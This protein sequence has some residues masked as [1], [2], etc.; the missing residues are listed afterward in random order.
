MYIILVLLTD[1]F[2]VHLQALLQQWKDIF[3][4]GVAQALKSLP[5]NNRTVNKFV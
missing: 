3:Q 1:K 4:T 5:D 2:M